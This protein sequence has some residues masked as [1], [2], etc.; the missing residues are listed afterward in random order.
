MRLKTTL[1]AA[2]F[3]QKNIVFS[4]EDSCN[5]NVLAL[6]ELLLHLIRAINHDTRDRGLLSNGD[7][8][9]PPFVLFPT[10]HFF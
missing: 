10:N 5:K 1:V 6:G 2:T 4:I 7:G 9:R 8:K 3:S